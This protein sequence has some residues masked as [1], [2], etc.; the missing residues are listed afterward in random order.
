MRGMTMTTTR[1]VS[2]AV[3]VAIVSVIGFGLP[4]AA[5]LGAQ[6]SAFAEAPTATPVSVP[7]P[8]SVS[9]SAV[10][11]SP[12]VTANAQV[13]VLPRSANG[14]DYQIYVGLPASYASQPSRRY[15]VLYVCDGYWDFA[16]IN[17][18]YGGL[19]YDRDAPEI[20][21]V[22]FGYPG[23]SPDF[24]ALRAYDY[25]PVANPVEDRD[26]KRTGHAPAFLR[27]IETEI[28]PF[29]EREYRADHGFRVLGGS[30]LGGLFTLYAMLERPGLFQGYIAPSPAVDWA[31]DWLF[32]REKEF[33]TTH[34]ELP[35]RVFMSG[36]GAEAPGFLAAIKRFSEQ[37]QA[38]HYTGLR[39][40]WR[41]IDGERH[42]GTK[43]ESYNRALRFIF[44]PLAPSPNDK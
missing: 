10:P 42:A 18:F 7:V 15:P 26:G 16:V 41:L 9:V 21:I 32:D 11:V 4:L 17:G 5:R 24:G 33:A 14:R 23:A 30:S 44:A 6:R 27:A 12:H 1:R 29:V 35:A 8:V 37:L 38:H 34:K 28:I 40:R 25:T 3:V 36:A 20:I 19:I 31:H 2:S 39:Y 13:R 43:P 22:G